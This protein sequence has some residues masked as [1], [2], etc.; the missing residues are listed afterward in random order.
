MNL[1]G[2]ANYDP[3]VAVTKATT[4]L[5]AMTAFDT[6][7]LRVSFTIPSHGM[8]TVKI[9]CVH[10]GSTTTAQVLLGCL[11]GSTLRGRAPVTSNLLGTAV[12]TTRTKLEASF[13]LTGL[14]PGAV[15]WD[16]AYG[17][18][19]VSSANGAIKYGGP[20]NT[21]TD[22]AFGGFNFEIWDPQPQ[23]TTAQLIIDS[24]GRAAADMRAISTDATAAD[25]A[26][27]FFDGTGYA[28]TNN[29]MPTTTTVTNMVTANVTQ[30]SGD[31]T[32]AD[33]LESYT[34]GTTPMP[35]NVTQIS[36]DATAADNLE[37]AH[38][39][40]GYAHTGNTYPW[41]AAWDAEVQ[42]EVDDALVARGLDHLVNASVTGTDI[43]DNSI[44][45]KMVSKSATA[46][47]DTFV[48]TT[49]ALEAI[50][51][52]ETDIETDTQDIQVRLP[53]ALSASGN[54]KADIKEIEDQETNGYLGVIRRATAQGGGSS[55]ITLDAGA[56]SVNDF[57][58]GAIVE[59]V[60]GAGASQTPRVVNSYNGTTK[61]A[62][63][64]PDQWA[65]DVDNTSVFIIRGTSFSDVLLWNQQFINSADGD[66]NI[67]AYF[68]NTE[69]TD[70][71]NA[72]W[73]LAIETGY[74]AKQS[75][76]LMLSALAGKLSGAAT[77]TVT[78]RNAADSKNRIVATVDSD[79]NRSAV[80]HDVSD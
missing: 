25:N 61:Q 67:P 69:L 54:M 33:N 73:S 24:G 4:S 8:V 3:A 46:D 11:E 28:C 6:T 52:K 74:T 75:M 56:S 2:A 40:A 41:T 29:V 16:A 5:L 10:H 9:T 60:S 59:V 12:A 58:R 17:V 31:S 71:A 42:S 39:G 50:R 13:T 68:N 19:I 43:T 48:N 26:E 64:S 78:I 35:V 30:I 23:T 70:V 72:V 80:T 18:E 45:A 51:D 37:A 55:Y 32:S 47:W 77:A 14:T 65:Q 49:D 38:D 27:A 36:G 66:G 79:G 63:I 44:I 22:D 1:L 34:D 20:N 21:T 7:N 57:Y 76:R 62:F 15:N 53:A